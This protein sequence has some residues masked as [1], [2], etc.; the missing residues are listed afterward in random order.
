MGIF[1]FKKG[2]K[3][4]SNF[5]KNSKYVVIAVYQ[6]KSSKDSDG[7][8]FY[9]FKFFNDISYYIKRRCLKHLRLFLYNK[10]NV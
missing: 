4:T 6:Y 1:N 8:K 3:I 10:G 5:L 7:L 2:A 9:L